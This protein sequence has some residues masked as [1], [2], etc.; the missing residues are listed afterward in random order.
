MGPNLSEPPEDE[1]RWEL[2]LWNGS[3]WY[4]EWFRRRL[5]WLPHASHRRLEDLRPNLAPGSWELLL[6]GIRAHLERQE[7][8]NLNLGVQLVGGRTEIW[9]VEGA[10]ERTAAGQPV[11]LAGTMKD[12]TP[13]F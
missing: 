9:H 11:Y 4:S 8:L 10:A 13:P 3:V 7:P 2:D 12:I 5:Q 6:Q 1:G